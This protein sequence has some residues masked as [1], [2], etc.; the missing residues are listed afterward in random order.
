MASGRRKAV[1]SILI[2]LKSLSSVAQILLVAPSSTSSKPQDKM[3]R[4]FLLDVIVRERTTVF[5]LLPG[6]NEALL[7]WRDA[8]FVLDFRLDI[9]DGVGR[10]DFEGDGF[11]RY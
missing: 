2:E 7:V 4:A 1:L 6:K 5:K 10:F 9:V 3:Q 8:F 11:P